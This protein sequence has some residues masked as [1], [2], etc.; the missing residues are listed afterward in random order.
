MT[1]LYARKRRGGFTL[2]ELLIVIGLLGALTALVLPA[3]MADREEALGDI[4][5]YNQAGTLRALKQYQQ[6]TGK[7]PTGM[8]TGLTVNTGASSRSDAMPGLPE[9]QA[10]NINLPESYYALTSSE[11]A[12]LQAAGINS[13]AYDSGL[14]YA[15]VAANTSVLRVTENWLDDTPAAYTFNGMSVADYESQGAKVFVFYVAPTTDWEAGSGD[16]SDWSKGN[17]QISIDLPGKCPVPTT[18]TNGGDPD[19]AYYMAYI[20]V[21]ADTNELSAAASGTGVVAPSFEQTY[22]V[23]ESDATQAAEDAVGDADNHLTWQTGGDWVTTAGVTSRIANYYYDPDG[24]PGNSDDVT[25]TVTFSIQNH[26]GTGE[27]ELV[28]TSCPECG[29]LNP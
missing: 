3:M 17:V 25:G 22:Y 24:T 10:T 28:G 12:A 23:D 5:D 8:H 16:N 19:F 2:I 26:E 6:V 9:A 7:L 14:H 15:T 13:V 20:A 21:W 11:A 27:A 1:K 29:V 18:D 4:C